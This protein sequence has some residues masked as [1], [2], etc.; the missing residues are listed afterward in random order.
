MRGAFH[1]TNDECEG[2]VRSAMLH[3]ACSTQTLPH[4]TNRRC[5]LGYSKPSRQPSR[6]HAKTPS[7]SQTRALR[8]QAPATLEVL[9]LPEDWDSW[10]MHGSAFAGATQGMGIPRPISPISSLTGQPKDNRERASQSIARTAHLCAGS[11]KLWSTLAYELI[12]GTCAMESEG[13]NK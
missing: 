8:S 9:A 12:A 3:A 6:P 13:S 11:R 4:A 7:R 2:S 1:H 5:M 10:F